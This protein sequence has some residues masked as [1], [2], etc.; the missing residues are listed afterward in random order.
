[1]VLYH[2]VC[3]AQWNLFCIDYT[4]AIFRPHFL[5]LFTQRKILKFKVHS[6]CWIKDLSIY[7]LNVLE[8]PIGCYRASSIT[9]DW[10]GPWTNILYLARLPL[11]PSGAPPAAYLEGSGGNTLSYRPTPLVCCLQR[12]PPP[13]LSGL[14]SRARC[15]P[16]FPSGQ[17]RQTCWWTWPWVTHRVCCHSRWPAGSIFVWLHGTSRERSAEHPRSEVCWILTNKY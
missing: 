11:C 15:L 16:S 8:C 17:L 2:H 5:G 13:C 10:L 4:C 6:T 12:L 14:R 3:I 9:L 7:M 1:M